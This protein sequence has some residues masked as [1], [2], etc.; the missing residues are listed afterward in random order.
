M[1]KNKDDLL[2][3]LKGTNERFLNSS[4]GQYIK[5]STKKNPLTKEEE[6]KI[7]EILMKLKVPLSAEIDR[8]R[9]EFY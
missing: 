3:K 1:N 8:Q 4:V 2:E 9:K 6:N 7:I 5:E